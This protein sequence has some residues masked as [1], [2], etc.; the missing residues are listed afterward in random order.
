MANVSGF[1]KDDVFSHI[2]P[3]EAN[4]ES[5]GGDNESPAVDSPKLVNFIKTEVDDVK[6]ETYSLLDYMKD[7]QMQILLA[8]ILVVFVS[9]HY[10]KK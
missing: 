5:N 8:S 9:Y 1:E 7:N 2:E 10:V 6:N 4:N 3:D